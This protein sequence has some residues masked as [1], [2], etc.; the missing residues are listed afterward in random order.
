MPDWKVATEIKKGK[1]AILIPRESCQMSPHVICLKSCSCKEV[2]GCKQF[3]GCLISYN[4]QLACVR[5]LEVIWLNMHALLRHSIKMALWWLVNLWV[6]YLGI[7]LVGQQKRD[8]H[9]HRPGWRCSAAGA[10]QARPPSLHFS[11][12]CLSKGN[13]H[14]RSG[15]GMMGVM[16]TMKVM[17]I[18]IS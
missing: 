14:L 2:S 15:E 12:V 18:W 17:R 7:E 3:G 9:V 6:P 8:N 5:K 10:V 13:I 1:V 4:L 16:R 11:S